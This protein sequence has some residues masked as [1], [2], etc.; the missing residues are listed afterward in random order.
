MFHSVWISKE[1]PRIKGLSLLQS[2]YRE[3]K[4]IHFLSAD[5]YSLDIVLPLTWPLIILSG[6]DESFTDTT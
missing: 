3:A 6:D 5:P 4:L 2:Y 1:L